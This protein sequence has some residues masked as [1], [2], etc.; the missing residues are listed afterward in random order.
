MVVVGIQSYKAGKVLVI[1]HTE[2][3]LCTAANGHNMIL[4]GIIKE[5]KESLQSP[6]SNSKRS[7]SVQ[8]I[9]L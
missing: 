9:R 8:N 7:T 2:G 1:L 4:V 5:C 6:T 3:I